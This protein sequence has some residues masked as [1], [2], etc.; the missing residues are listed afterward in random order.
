M[1]SFCMHYFDVLLT[2]FWGVIQTLIRRN[3][4]N[5]IRVSKKEDQQQNFCWVWHYKHCVA[6]ILWCLQRTTKDVQYTWDAPGSNLSW[7]KRKLGI[8]R[9]VLAQCWGK[10]PLSQQAP[11]IS[12][13]SEGRWT[14]NSL[15]SCTVS[16]LERAILGLVSCPSNT[17]TCGLEELGT[18]PLTF[19]LFDWILCSN[20]CHV[21][22][23][24]SVQ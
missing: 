2:R 20:K 18:E 23:A 22:I 16:W 6:P 13:K 14:L 11:D 8:S 17:S 12:V 5:F 9:L 19:L 10:L 24:T 15:L 21:V 4:L 3:V 1:W 7:Q